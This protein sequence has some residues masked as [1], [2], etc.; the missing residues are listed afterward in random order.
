MQPSAVEVPSG[1]AG[2]KSSSRLLDLIPPQKAA[3]LLPILKA[4]FPEYVQFESPE[5]LFPLT[6]EAN[7]DHRPYI[8]CALNRFNGS[9]R[10]PWSNLYFPPLD[11][12]AP[13]PGDNLRKLEVL[14][15][16]ALE[17]YVKLYYSS[18]LLSA[19][20]MARKHGFMVC[21]LI[22]SPSVEI[23][24][25][26]FIT[27]KLVLRQADYI[28]SAAYLVHF[29]RADFAQNNDNEHLSLGF[30]HK[31]EHQEEAQ[32][33]SNATES[34]VA[35]IGRIIEVFHFRRCSSKLLFYHFQR[36]GPFAG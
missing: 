3:E 30:F 20:C 17:H 8:S 31:Q 9:S 36:A 18:A 16:A 25:I 27:E 5:N 14:A 13:L 23:A 24:H 28:Q 6:V 29:D 22:K 32:L 33:S 7:S 35:N 10:S 1:Q 34:H 11:G 4:H 21:V 15:N 12:E 2:S 19:Y 26:I